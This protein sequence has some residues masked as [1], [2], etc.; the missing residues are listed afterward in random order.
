MS[1]L[2]RRL[3][4]GRTTAALATSLIPTT[5]TLAVVHR[6]GSSSAL[7][8]VLAAELVPML[9]LLPVAGVF[10]DRFP[11]RRIVL[12]ADLVRAAAQAGIGAELLIA[13]TV[14]PVLAAL[15]AVTGAA[16]AFGTPAVRTLVTATVQGPERQRFNARLSIWQGLAQF[17][18]PAVAGTLTLGIGTGWSSLL[19]AA[20][21]TGSALT[22]GALAVPARA[23][24]TPAPKTTP[25]P[26]AAVPA[27]VPARAS[28]LGDL[29]AGWAETRRHPWFI[30]NVMG[31]GV[32]H[33]AAGFLLTLGPVIAI[34]HLGGGT[35]WVVILQT[36]T[37]GMLAGVW[38][39]G[40]RRVRRPLVGVAVGASAYAL[41]LACLAARAPLPIVLAAYF[42]AMFGLGVLD[43][44]WE[45]TVQQRI[46]ADALGRVGSFDALI[47]FAARPLGLAVAAPVAAAVGTTAPLAVAAV[48]VAAA[49]LAVLALPEVRTADP[50]SSATITAADEEAAL[51]AAARAAAVAILAAPEPMPDT[52]PAPEPA[53]EPGPVPAP[54]PGPAPAREPA[55]APAA[56][57]KAGA[58]KPAAE[59]RRPAPAPPAAVQMANHPGRAAAVTDSP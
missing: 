5:L 7:G 34:R 54:G 33:L 13:G 57:L 32:W 2:Q 19:T 41:P 28:F 38:A 23:A 22:L 53:P 44:L 37:V 27:P 39:A 26:A 40:R 21:F 10:A 48:L 49:N 29:R 14:L 6:T 59:P 25:G 50:A 52:W 45:T 11:A 15:A 3:L 4:Y 12:A 55:A 9:L 56:P 16:V 20:L 35:A 47:S 31:H 17:T 42:T 1:P 51:A 8:L 18:G 24:T 36:G 58:P 30:A 46:P 43:P